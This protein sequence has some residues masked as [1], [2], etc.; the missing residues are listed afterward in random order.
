MID[1]VLVSI[2][3]RISNILDIEKLFKIID[4]FPIEQ[5]ET[6]NIDAKVVKLEEELKARVFLKENLFISFS[7]GIVNKD[8]YRILNEVYSNEYTEIENKIET[9]KESIIAIA[10]EK[11]QKYNWVNQYKKYR[12][13]TELN[14]KM[15]NFLIDKIFVYE[16]Y[17]IDIRFSDQA[18][19]ENAISLIRNSNKLAEK[20]EG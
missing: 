10:A 17:K 8:N 16:G 1:A 20:M 3:N 4:E 7:E 18:S 12:N 11:E 6:I 9:L 2:R 14:R 19:Y 5:E 13:I 15:V